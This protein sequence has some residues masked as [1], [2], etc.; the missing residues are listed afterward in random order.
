MEKLPINFLIGF[1]L[2]SFLSMAYY[3]GMVA[4]EYK[5]KIEALNNIIKRA[6]KSIQSKEIERQMLL[7]YIEEK[8][9]YDAK[10]YKSI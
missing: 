8:K 9:N 3:D 7:R 5:V 10:I 1:L 6:D 4:K 2:G